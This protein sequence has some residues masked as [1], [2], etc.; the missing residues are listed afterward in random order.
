MTVAKPPLPPRLRVYAYDVVKTFGLFSVLPVLPLANALRDPARAAWY[1]YTIHLVQ[2]ATLPLVG[3]VKMAL[4]L[5]L[6]W[7]AAGLWGP[8][9]GAALGVI[10]YQALSGGMHLDG[11]ADTMD[12][13]FAA[14]TK[15]PRVAMRDPN[16]GALGVVYLI[17]YLALFG[18]FGGLVL[19]AWLTAPEPALA[20]ALM[21]ALFAAAVG[22]R[23]LCHALVVTRFGKGVEND[24]LTQVT[25]PYPWWRD[26][27]RL[28]PAVLWW[29][30]LVAVLA[31]AG[32]GAA[33]LLWLLGFGLLGNVFVAGYVLRHRVLPTLGFVNGDVLGFAICLSELLHLILAALVFV[34]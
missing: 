3:L 1:G 6:A 20:A 12:A 26:R 8:A 31:L 23:L 16:V 27:G 25:P 32:G 18:L 2:Y 10:A 24:R 29:A 13:L 4:A 30:S 21:A 19:H 33:P 5:A 14:G 28:W 34:R 15:N 7:G 22:P 17:F 9:A 11:F